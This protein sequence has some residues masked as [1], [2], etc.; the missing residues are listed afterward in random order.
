MDAYP[1]FHLDRFVGVVDCHPTVGRLAPAVGSPDRRA[2]AR[3][4]MAIT[5]RIRVRP[6]GHLKKL[7]FG[8]PPAR[9]SGGFEIPTMP[10]PQGDNFAEV[11]LVNPLERNG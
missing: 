4:L 9:C 5:S 3:F 10:A 2:I 7:D 8:F 6:L 1:P 11:W